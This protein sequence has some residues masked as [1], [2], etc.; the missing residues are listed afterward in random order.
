M[1]N[2]MKVAYSW[3]GA[4]LVACAALVVSAKPIDWA[5]A[6]QVQKGTRLAKLALETPRLMK[7]NVM[8]VDLSTPGLRFACTGRDE[9]WGEPM[10]DFP[11]LPIRTK[12]ERTSV[13]LQQQ[14]AAGRNAVVA[15]NTTPWSPWCHP[16][17]HVYADPAGLNISDGVVVSDRKRAKNPLFVAWKDGRCEITDSIPPN[18]YKDVQV[19]NS[20]FDIILR[21]GKRTG[22]SKRGPDLNP[23]MAV[24]L[25]ADKRWLYLVTVDGR[26]K[27]W[28]LGASYA[29]LCDILLDAGAADGVNMDGGGSTTLLYWNGQKPVMVNR[30]N[31]NST[32]TR[33][34][35]INVAILIP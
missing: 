24:G 8:R 28:S 9:K 21:N 33:K 13:F 31:A 27:D 14:R 12:R 35:A 19:A 17:T 3:A 6:E 5:K 7:V 15:F 30:H 1:K 2:T 4:L 23:R 34:N 16:Y 18:R 22:S 29:D 11:S 26:Q 32:Y 10:P 25:S 20:G